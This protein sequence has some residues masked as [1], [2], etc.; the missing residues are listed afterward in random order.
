MAI[1]TT[2]TAITIVTEALIQADEGDSPPSALITRAT[3]F[4][5]E[6]IK[7]KIAGKKNW[8]ILETTIASIP[9][10]HFNKIT[11]PADYQKLIK[12]TF[13]DGSTKDTLQTATSSTI[14]LASDEDITEDN[15]KGRLIFITSGNAKAEKARI[16]TYNETTKQAGIS[17][18][19]GTTPSSGDYMIADFE[20]EL[21]YFPNEAIPSINSAGVPSAISYYDGE[22]YLDVVPDKSTYAIVFKYVLAIQKVDLTNSRYGNILS[23][24]RVPLLNGVLRKALFNN[25]NEKYAESKKLEDESILLLMKQDGRKNLQRT[26]QAVRSAG[27]LPIDN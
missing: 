26:N 6:E 11:V 5:L 8:K 9:D 23:D 1:P 17:P 13:Y 3:N 10:I 4:W 18:D 22:F 20:K 7:N 19:W 25:N 21:E 27:G 14:D 15:A 24:W 2:P 16:V 12:A